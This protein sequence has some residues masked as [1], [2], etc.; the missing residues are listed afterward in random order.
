MINI[1]K[2]ISE[3]IQALQEQQQV[4]NIQGLAK[5]LERMDFDQDGQNAMIKILSNAYKKGGDQGV[6][7]MYKR[8]TAVDIFA[9]S[10]GRYVFGAQPSGGGE[11]RLEESK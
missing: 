8:F 2:I 1:K 11:P 3:E 6:I 5:L 10:N 9:I 4:Y 7:D